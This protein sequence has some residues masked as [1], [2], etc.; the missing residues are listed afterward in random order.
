MSIKQLWIPLKRM[1]SSVFLHTTP[2]GHIFITWKWEDY[3]YGRYRCTEEELKK[4]V[5]WVEIEPQLF[6]GEFEIAGARNISYWQE[7]SKL[8]LHDKNFPNGSIYYVMSMADVMQL[9][10]TDWVV[11]DEEG[12]IKMEFFFQKR[13]W[14]LFICPYSRKVKQQMAD[15]EKKQSALATWYKPWEI[16]IDWWREYAYLGKWDVKCLSEWDTYW[17]W[18]WRPWKSNYNQ[19]ISDSHIFINMDCN[20]SVNN[21]WSEWP[22]P[23]NIKFAWYK[24]KPRRQITKHHIDSKVLAEMLSFLN[25]THTYRRLDQNTKAIISEIT[26]PIKTT[27][28]IPTALQL[29][30]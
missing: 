4:K 25:S 12:T 13:G 3:R 20:K 19:V 23:Y 7:I 29:L 27:L 10:F 16:I 18:G 22:Y 8:T 11:I 15:E 24:S 30:I 6:Y 17:D 21:A 28:N 26:Y 1:A 9:F 2:E 5:P 14:T